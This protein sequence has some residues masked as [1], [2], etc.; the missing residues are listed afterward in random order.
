MLLY[1]VDCVTVCHNY[2]FIC[3]T[4]VTLCFDYVTICKLCYCMPLSL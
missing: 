3:Y 1:G 2:V 4:C